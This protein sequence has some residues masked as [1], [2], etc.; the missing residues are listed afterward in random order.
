MICCLGLKQLGRPPEN[1]LRA[2]AVDQVVG[3]RFVELFRRAG[4]AISFCYCIRM[5]IL[6]W[7]FLNNKMEG[8]FSSKSGGDG[9]EPNI[10]FHVNG[11]GGIMRLTNRIK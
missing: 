2:L 8:R 4:W 3:V 1:A 5:S 6:G 10:L 11:L 7:A 9:W